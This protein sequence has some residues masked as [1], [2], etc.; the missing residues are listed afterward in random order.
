MVETLLLVDDDIDTLRLVGL[1]L[2]R[3]GYKIIAANNGH[4]AIKLA[5]EENPDL[6][7]L[8]V[9]MPDLDGFE[10]ARML[11]SNP[12]TVETPII[13]FTA[14]SQVEDRV[15]GLEAGA[16]AYLSKPTQPRELFAQVKAMLSRRRKTQP[17][18]A[19]AASRGMLIGVISSKGGLGVSTVA[20]NLGIMIREETRDDIIIAEYRPG[21][22]GIS[23]DLGYNQPDGLHQLLQ[24]DPSEISM[25]E[26]DLEIIT[27][28]TGVRLLLAS[29]DPDDGQ[30]LGEVENFDAITQNIQYLGKY[31]IIDLGSTINRVARNTIPSMDKV[32]IVMEPTPDNL[33]Q[34]KKMLAAVR[35]MG[36]SD[37]SII[38]MLNNRVRSSVQLGWSEI[39]DELDFEVSTVITPAPELAYQGSMDNMPMVVIQPDG[40]TADQFRKLANVVIGLSS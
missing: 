27:H 1:M 6:I 28:G 35:N 7:L 33:T 19:A 11:R 5:K 31:V 21:Y 10:V 4:Q 12:G 25:R 30:Y 9:M 22:G 38:L 26:V 37:S 32:I 23:L 2:E 20:V 16:D 17:T 29:P 34:T 8:D 3:Q 18:P 36:Q 13:M 40:L 24:K 15:I 14:K 39:Q